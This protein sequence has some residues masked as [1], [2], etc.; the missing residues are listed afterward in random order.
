MLYKNELLENE[1]LIC[2]SSDR[3]KASL[4]GTNIFYGIIE[5]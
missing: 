3:D 1:D 5:E 4:V 2:G